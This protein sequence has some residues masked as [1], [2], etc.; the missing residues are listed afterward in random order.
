M[1]YSTY[2]NF[3]IVIVENNST[4]L[5]TFEYYQELEKDSKIKVVTWKGKFNYS[6][7]NNYGAGF[8]LWKISS[9]VK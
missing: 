9:F 2:K 1:D 7:I 4:E 6:A 8:L 3:E 5:R